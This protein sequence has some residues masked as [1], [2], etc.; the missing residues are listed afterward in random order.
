LLW[1]EKQGETMTKTQGKILGVSLMLIFVLAFFAVSAKADDIKI[2]GPQGTLGF[3]GQIDAGMSR[4]DTGAT[5]LNRA[6]EG[7]LTTSR[8]GFNGNSKDLGGFNFNFDLEGA[9]KPQTGTLGSTTT[10]GSVFTR[11][12][13]VGLNGTAGQVK[14][15]TTHDLSAASDIDTLTWTF[16]NFTN[17]PVNGTSLELGVDVNNAVKYQTPNLNGFQAQVGYAGQSSSA[18]TNVKGNVESASLTYDNSKL[19]AGAGYAYKDATT[20]NGE[21]SAKTV[22]AA[23]NFGVAQVGAAYIWGDNSTTGKVSSNAAVYSVSVPLDSKGLVA[24][25]VFA[26]SKDANQPTDNTGKGY[27]MGVTKEFIPGAS[28]YAAYSWV[29]NDKNSTMYMN[30]MTLPTAGNDP[31]LATIGLNYQF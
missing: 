30:G 19:K 25:G 15:G 16:G 29:N 4:Y 1:Q 13:W 17:F 31:K 6:G 22:G 3:Y 11:E 27:T 5:T 8:L 26:T 10:T 24:H 9:L 18:T 2:S 20:T 23:Y 28:L 14:V 21:L 7:N 12:A